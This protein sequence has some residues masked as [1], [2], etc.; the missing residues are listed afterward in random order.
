MAALRFHV[1]AACLTL[2][3]THTFFGASELYIAANVD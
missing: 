1:T 3:L 2:S